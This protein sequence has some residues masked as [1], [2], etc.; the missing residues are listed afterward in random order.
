[1]VR[2]SIFANNPCVLCKLD[3]KCKTPRMEPS[4]PKDAVFYVLGEAPGKEE[5]KAGYQ[6]YEDA[7][8]GSVIRDV[9]N[10]LDI[11]DACR[12]NNSVRCR[13][14]KNRDPKISEIL[15]CR[16]SIIKDIQKVEPI[17]ILALGNFAMLSLYPHRPT[18]ITVLNGRVIPNWDLN[19]WVIPVYHPSFVL[20]NRY[21]DEE[22]DYDIIFKRDIE[23]ALNLDVLELSGLPTPKQMKKGIKP[24]LNWNDLNDFFEMLFEAD[25]FA[26]DYETVDLRPFGGKAKI[27][28]VSFCI[29]GKKSY[30]F[31][32]DKHDAPWTEKQNKKIKKWLREIF[33]N[34]RTTKIAHNMKFE[35]EWTYAELG[36][37][38]NGT[39]EDTQLLSYTYD[40][41]TSKAIRAHSLDFVGLS[42]FGFE[43]KSMIEKYIKNMDAA[44]MIPMLDYGALDSKVTFLAEAEFKSRL[45]EEQ[46]STYRNFLAEEVPMLA[47]S[48][49]KGVKIDKK[50]LSRFEI[51][52]KKKIDAAEKKIGSLK[53]VSTFR[54][55]HK[56]YPNLNS[57]RDVAEI[58]YNILGLEAWKETKGRN[59][60]TDAE[61]LES[62]ARRSKFC[63]F[64]LEL[65]EY[66]TLYTNRVK[67]FQ[68]FMWADGRIHTNWNNTDVKTGRT[69]SSEPNLQ[70]MDKRKHPEIRAI[71]VADEGYI[72][73]IFDYA[74]IEARNIA[75]ASRCKAFCKAIR[76]GYDIHADF[77]ER[78]WGKK[79]FKLDPKTYRQ[80][81]KNG[82]VFPSFYGAGPASI[83]R[84]LDLSYEK[85]LKTQK[86]LWKMFPGVRDWQEELFE[87]YYENLYVETL[88]KRRRHAPLTRNQILN[89]PIQGTASDFLVWSAK[90]IEKQL[91]YVPLLLVH[92]ELVIQVP[93]D[94]DLFDICDDVSEI[95]TDLPEDIFPFINVPVKVDCSVG[96]DWYN[97]I[98]LEELEDAA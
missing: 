43:Y 69:S 77:A 4:G 90:E 74:Q 11:E 57:D 7:P 12:F 83:S 59:V 93:E 37:E 86:V 1:M 13:P 61:V 98:D 95:M 67:T 73:L 84:N 60:S 89:S 50:E 91:G 28:S 97:T 41:R 24:I 76:E 54:K 20:R 85:I 26:F 38:I 5:D 9:L 14:P 62:Y 34:K 36:V 64:L 39:L 92:D 47:K 29:D 63:R 3:Q 27:V 6:F 21:K 40:E 75:M 70:N 80:D 45:D 23:K 8:A 78:L 35:Y 96:Y 66:R 49:I 88:T 16:N 22:S 15:A 55:K 68:K 32:I 53:L 17:V 71:I 44:P 10:Y 82:L 56:K 19:C 33:V 79:E 65:R 25:R 81:S 18:G 30:A 31:P 72:L 52:T 46:I 42:L 94:E 87:F 2:K 58:L 51:Y 48:Q